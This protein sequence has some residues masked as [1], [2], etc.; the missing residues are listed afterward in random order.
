MATK[1]KFIR[2]H[3]EVKTKDGIYKMVKRDKPLPALPFNIKACPVCN[4]EMKVSDGTLMRMHKSC[5][6][7]LSKTSKKFRSNKFR[8]IH[9]TTSI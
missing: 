7:L 5:K 3:M 8:N 4:E 6:K 2:T 1:T 9:A